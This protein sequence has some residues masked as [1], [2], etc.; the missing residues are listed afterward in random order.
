VVTVISRRAAK[1]RL[2]R[3]LVAVLSLAALLLGPL[4]AS[5]TVD[6][7]HEGH[8]YLGTSSP[9]AEKPES[10]LW[11]NDGFWWGSLFDPAT[12]GYHI[13]RLDAATQSWAKAGTAL[14]NRS[15]SNADVLWHA[16]TNKLYVAS[17]IFTSTGQPA[18]EAESSRLYRFSYS[19]ATKSYVLDTG[20]PVLI[21][22]S[23]GE[24]LV[25]DR[26]SRGRLWATW[27]EG[28]RVYVTH[29]TC[30]AASCDDRSWV[31]P[32]IPPVDG[33]HP[34]STVVDGDDISAVVAFDND[35]IGLMW[36]NQRDSA[37]YFAV[38]DDS[39]APG[40]WRASRTA[41]QGPGSADDHI[42]L[43]T[44]LAD[45]QGRVYAVIKTS[46]SSSSAPLIMVLVR[47]PSN[48]EWTSHRHSTKRYNQTRPIVLI[49]ESAQRLHVFASD[50]GGGSIY[51]KSAPLSNISFEDGKGTPVIHDDDAPDLNNATS[52]KQNVNDETGLVVLASNNTTRH[53]W[54]H[55]DA[56]GG[57][58]PEPSPSPTPEPSPS[59][60]PAP[61]GSGPIT[62]RSA[63]SGAN[64]TDTS[65]TISRPPGIASGD[66]LLASIDARGKPNFTPPSGW[67]LVRMDENGTTMRKATYVR[68]AGSQEPA[69]YTWQLSNSQAASG[70]IV[71]YAGVDLANPVVAHNGQVNSE[72]S[73]FITAPSVDVSTA[74]SMVVGLFGIAAYTSI[75]PPPDMTERAQEGTPST[76]Y[77]VT[78]QASDV[79]WAAPGQTGEVTATADN[80]AR[81]I[82]QLVVL[83]PAQ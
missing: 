33:V 71:A 18:S 82:G 32:F 78:S 36:S 58:T 47:D 2:T 68:A 25:I 63:S 21:N 43:A 29:T 15:K 45:G 8:S 4:Q 22:R 37:M 59:P 20:F 56:L 6:V 74:D 57:Q 35:K 55:Y 49:D 27:V 72:A 48:G 83:R 66:L 70:V 61:D 53:Y 13:Y 44:L 7:G 24:A 62:F 65:L 64:T 75:S 73:T 11:W 67:Q 42:N 81:S 5:A 12:S 28:G 1:S 77:K 39:S 46:H 17:H 50:Q 26:D 51:H 9:T 23:K 19:S 54:H 41:V 60:T 31:S 34:N 69:S 3:S 38:R 52:T 76:R 80:S 30:D 14:D 40:T 16:P 10:K 79:P